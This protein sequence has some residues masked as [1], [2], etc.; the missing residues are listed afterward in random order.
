MFKL[1]WLRFGNIGVPNWAGI[2][3]KFLG[4]RQDNVPGGPR[5]RGLEGACP[6]QPTRGSGGEPQGIFAFPSIWDKFWAFFGCIL[7]GFPRVQLQTWH[8]E[9][10]I[11][12]EINFTA[13]TNVVMSYTAQNSYLK[14]QFSI[15]SGKPYQQSPKVKS[16]LWH[17]FTRSNDQMF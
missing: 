5:G 7:D 16:S 11:R 17:F 9:V 13:I 10:Q 4:R 1:F 14:C 2:Y 3:S 12:N 8:T 6:S 15:Y